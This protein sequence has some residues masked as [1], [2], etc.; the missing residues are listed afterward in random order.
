MVWTLEHDSTEQTF[1]AWGL[2]GLTLSFQPF[3]TGTASFQSSAPAFDASLP[4]ARGDSCTIRADG[5]PVFRGRFASPR[6]Q[7]QGSMSSIAY[8][9]RDAWFDLESRFYYQTTLALPASNI[10]TLAT[11][12]QGIIDYAAGKGVAIQFGSA[13]ELGVNTPAIEFRDQ[14]CASMLIALRRLIPDVAHYL[15]HTT[16][17]PTIH[18]VRRAEAAA[19]ALPTTGAEAFDAIQIES[20][21][22]IQSSGVILRYPRVI[23]GGTGEPTLNVLIDAYPPGLTGDEENLVVATFDLR[24]NS[25][26]KQVLETTNIAATSR[27]WWAQFYP[28]IQPGNA[29]LVEG[30]DFTF[31]SLQRLVQDTGGSGDWVSDSGGHTNQI[32]G[33]GVPGW[34]NDAAEVLVRAKLKDFFLNGIYHAEFQL[35]GRC[36]AT[37]LI[38]GLY[39][40]ETTPAEVAPSGLAQ[41][42][43]EA[44]SVL[45][46]Q[47]RMT[48]EMD[49][50]ALPLPH[51]ANVF[52]ITGGDAAA[53]GWDSMRA[54]AREVVID[55]DNATLDV[56]F[57][58]PAHLSLQDL[59]ELARIAGNGRLD[60]PQNDAANTTSGG[61]RKAPNSSAGGTVPSA[62]T[63]GFDVLPSGQIIAST[64]DNVTPSI[65]GTPLD[66]APPEFLTIP[67][68]GTRYVVMWVK[69][70]FQTSTEGDTIFVSPVMLDLE[71]AFTI[72][73]TEPTDADLVR[74]DPFAEP[75]KVK[76]ATFVN[77]G[78]TSQTAYGPVSYKVQDLHLG[79]GRAK[80]I[81]STTP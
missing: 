67:G 15:D 3:A 59:L 19:I 62:S 40:N 65:D 46:W 32:V 10:G 73:S 12:F 28:W 75:F 17:P 47:G 80:L 35:E 60:L 66:H 6:R 44:T 61:L 24:G 29:D 52:N 57:G 53:R 77:G 71:V 64:V 16:D 1:A 54:V 13:A 4:F 41:A 7:G 58:P 20:L 42:Y 50:L 26:Q 25:V 63:R 18:F 72:E 11:Q 38:G 76:W 9:V 30:E 69:G 45:H 55:V 48:R 78:K 74:D 37:S 79:D 14:T 39:V 51:S 56:S 43:Y 2:E 34:M 21:E 22:D 70:T 68:S 81:L 8:L 31:A 23:D 36:T 5:T 33:G 27:Q 49:E